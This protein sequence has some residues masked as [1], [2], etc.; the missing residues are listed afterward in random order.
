[1]QD[2]EYSFTTCYTFLYHK[3][4][5]RLDDKSLI[6]GFGIKYVAKTAFLESKKVAQAPNAKMFSLLPLFHEVFD[7]NNLP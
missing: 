2:L 6:Y 1:M 3:K 7:A 5:H 4:S